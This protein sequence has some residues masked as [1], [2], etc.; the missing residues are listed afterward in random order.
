MPFAK[1]GE[2]ENVLDSER[3][4]GR[5]HKF[6]FGFLMYDTGLKHREKSAL[7]I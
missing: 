1:N 2:N 7:K 3:E 6:N 5:D 4:Q